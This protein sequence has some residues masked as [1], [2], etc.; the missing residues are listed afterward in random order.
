MKLYITRHG[1]TKWNIETRLQGWND[2]DL[3][4]K[5]KQDASA[6]AS[7]LADVNFDHIYSSTQK[8][9]RE[10]AEI[11]KSDRNID[12]TELED[13]R[14]IGFGQWEGM[15]MKD[16][17][18]NYKGEFDVYLKK[19]HLYK[20]ILNGESYDEIFDRV[21]RA[22]KEII[23]NG[24]DNILIVS[25]GVTIKILT[26]IVKDISREDLYEIGISKGTSLNI[27][28][29]NEDGIEFILEGDTSH[30]S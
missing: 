10:T 14:E 27:C 18:D 3:T 13:L 25:H 8:R 2:S 24:G 15:T 26:A 20:P 11:I 23:K 17:Q 9:A 12:I 5:G 6:L 22:L 29:V 7:R 16:I 30:I 19:P 1:Q 21:N 28:Q 4:Q